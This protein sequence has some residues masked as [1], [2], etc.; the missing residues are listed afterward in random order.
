MDFLNRRAFENFDVNTKKDLQAQI[1]KWLDQI[2]GPGKLIEKFKIL[3]FQQDPNQ[4]DRIFLDIH[5]TPYFPA[6]N[7]VI[8]LDGQK[9]DDVDPNWKAEYKQQ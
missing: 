1:E 8:S 4:K 3:K 2:T 5:M 6:K 9:G 7:F